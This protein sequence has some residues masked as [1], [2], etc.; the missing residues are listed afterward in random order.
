MVKDTVKRIARRTVAT[1]FQSGKERIVLWF[2]AT[3]KR[4]MP[5]IK[6][7][8]KWAAILGPIVSFVYWV[9]RLALLANGS[10]Q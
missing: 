3:A 10:P 5:T 8:S 2:S 9:V 6:I 1:W 7:V 4:S